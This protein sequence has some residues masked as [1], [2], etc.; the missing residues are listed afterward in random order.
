MDT[1]R[2][3]RLAGICIA[4]V[5]ATGCTTVEGP[6]SGYGPSS[7]TRVEV[8]R[9]R[10]I[11]PRNEDVLVVAH[12]ACWAN[13][14]PENSL[15]AIEECIALG[16]DMIEI[17]VAL[18]KD[19]VP[20][21]MHD[22]TLDRTTDGIGLLSEQTL[23]RIQSLRLRAGAGGAGALTSEHAP[24]LRQALNAVRG[25]LMVNL[26][27]KGEAFEEAFAVVDEMNMHDHILMKMSARADEQR[28]VTAAFRGKT[29]FMP[30]IRECET[31]SPYRNCVSMLS[32]SVAS[33]EDYSPIAFEVLYLHEDFLVEGVTFMREREARI[34]V[35]TLSSDQAAGVTDRSA[36]DDPHGTWGRVIALGA[37]I[38]QTDRP[39]ELIRYLEEQNLRKF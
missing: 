5:A 6:V 33:Y 3:R 4:L 10:L 34:W 15:A 29:L 26:D 23:D 9:E 38:I 27:I 1:E 13:G 28:L 8:Y 2:I 32:D 19:G 25:H 16:V 11:N 24:T 14:A 20:V 17:D 7:G 39:A 21:L 22:T 35:N 18:T 36:L 12:R 30:V 37:N 31:P